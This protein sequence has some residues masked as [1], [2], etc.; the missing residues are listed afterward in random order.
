MNAKIVLDMTSFK[1][2]DNNSFS[3]SVSTIFNIDGNDSQK[4][5]AGGG[6]GHTPLNSPTDTIR[7][8]KEVEDFNLRK[9]AQIKNTNRQTKREKKY[10]QYKQSNKSQVNGGSL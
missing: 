9:I 8:S 1:I 4:S 3:V 2:S 6:G 7:V 10:K 5:V